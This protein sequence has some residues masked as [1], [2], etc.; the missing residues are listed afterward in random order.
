MRALIALLALLLLPATTSAQTWPAKPVRIIVPFPAG[1]VADVLARGLQAD[2]QA[3]LGQPVVI[4]NKPGA[5]GMVAGAEVAKSAPDG[6]TV[7]FTVNSHSINA[8]MYPK[9]PF[10][11][12]RDLRGVTLIGSLPQAL[13]ANPSAR[14]NTLK[15]FLAVETNR[16][17]GTGGVGS[18]GHFAAA[19]LESLS[20]VDL[21]HVPYRGAGPAIADVVGGQIPY[22][23][24]TLTSVLPHIKAGKLKAI[25]ITS[26]QRSPLVPNVPTIAESG[27]PGYDMDTWVGTFVPRPTP[28]AIVKTLHDATVE[29]LDSP[30]V[31]QR[32]EAQGTRIISGPPDQLDALVA[33][34]IKR[35]T[36][37]VRARG[38]KAE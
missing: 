16:S 30:D 26:L 37:I 3:A 7:S 24:S 5:D 34:D 6:Y 21:H 13:A 31:R 17:Y 11:T 9:L 25:A 10:D 28:N 29:A 12:E 4:D 20:G 2:L 14:A 8:A 32:L 35:Y 15:E 27:F 33:E 18:P 23:L 22:V 38:I 36:K 19:Y 1:G